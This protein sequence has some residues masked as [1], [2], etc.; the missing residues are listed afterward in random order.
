MLQFTGLTKKIPLLKCHRLPFQKVTK[1]T[2]LDIAKNP[3]WNHFVEKT[4]KRSKRSINAWR[5][6]RTYSKKRRWTT[7]SISNVDEFRISWSLAVSTTSG[8]GFRHF[9]ERTFINA[10]KGSP[11]LPAKTTHQEKK[12]SHKNVRYVFSPKGVSFCSTI[13]QIHC[14]FFGFLCL[15]GIVHLSEDANLWGNL[16]MKSTQEKGFNPLTRNIINFSPLAVANQE[17]RVNLFVLQHTGCTMLQD[18]SP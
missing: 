4:T 8:N 13:F 12:T 3:R 2:N 1:P 17:W 18:K 7:S 9:P 5:R 15:L 14:F 16:I 10:L 6:S 11:Y